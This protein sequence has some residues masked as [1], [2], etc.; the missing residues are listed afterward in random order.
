MNATTA[1]RAGAQDRNRR[2]RAEFDEGL[3]AA[4]QCRVALGC[5]RQ[6]G[7][8]D[9]A[10]W[11]QVLRHP[12][13]ACRPI[14]AEPFEFGRHR[15]R[16]R[17]RLRRPVHAH[18]VGFRRQHQRG[19]DVAAMDAV[20]LL[21]GRKRPV[22]IAEAMPAD[23]DRKHAEPRAQIARHRFHR[24]D[25]AAVAGDENKLAQTGAGQTVAELGPGR[26][27]G[28][29][30]QRQR[31]GKSQ[32]LGGDADALHRQERHRESSGNRSRTRA[33]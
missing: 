11:V 30:R 3:R 14:G 17:R 19:L 5:G 9:G 8:A 1:R 27:R 23:G 15:H 12:G 33:R 18:R 20:L 25:I 2:S 29:R 10:A 31:A 32:M 24:R 13:K 22:G 4:R 26:D 21:L 28:R 7:V 16:F 6:R